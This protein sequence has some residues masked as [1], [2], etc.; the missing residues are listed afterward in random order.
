MHRSLAVSLSCCVVV[1][2]A[3]PAAAQLNGHNL[4]GDYGLSSGTQP[5]PGLWVG[6]FYPNYNVDELRGRDGRKLPFQGDVN[7]QALAPWLWWVSDK[8]IFGANY[9]IFV[10]PSW[11]ESALE[12]PIL[13]LE[14]DTG[15]G[16]GDLYVQPINLGW[17]TKRADF[18]AGAGVFAPIGR[19][20]QGAENNTG[21]GMWSYE[22]FAGT[23]LYL[24][25]ARTWN[26]AATAFYET[27]SA[28]EDSKQKVGDILTVEG[29]L[30]RSFAGGALNVGLAYFAQWKVTGDN[31][32]LEGPMPPIALDLPKHRVLG[33]GPEIVLP[34]ASKKKLFG[35]LTLRYL[36]DFGVEANTQGRTF[37]LNFTVPVPSMPL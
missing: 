10:S 37:L 31:L 15:I 24:N 6:L 13:G 29:G 14:S 1:L 30:G 33:V 36:F 23:T 8:K 22:A 21:L 12:A 34:L 7:V 20:E 28:K 17:H 4:R 3:L 18:M 2:L 5:P 26:L 16:L 25:E 9:S 35:F 32:G 11:T 19:F 27:H